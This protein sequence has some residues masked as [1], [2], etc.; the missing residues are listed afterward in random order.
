M[1]HFTFVQALVILLLFLVPLIRRIRG[2]AGLPAIAGLMLLAFYTVLLVK[3]AFFPLV[4]DPVFGEAGPPRINGIPL[5]SI[6]DIVQH[7]APMTALRQIGGN[8]LLLAPLGLLAP[9]AFPRLRTAGRS[10]WLILAAAVGIEAVQL[11][12]SLLTGV[13]NRVVDIDDVLLNL[14]GGMA[15]YLAYF[16]LFRKRLARSPAA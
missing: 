2:R 15:G 6:L 16:R 4:W 12:L 9:L 13:P 8:L 5:R 7:T 3:T 1:I 11:L 14:L 10:F